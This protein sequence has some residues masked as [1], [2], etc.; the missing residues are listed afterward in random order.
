MELVQSILKEN[1]YYQAGRK[2]VVKG[3]MLHSV[4]CPQPNAEV[5]IKAWNNKYY[6]STCVHG[7]ID[8]NTGKVY[9]TLPWNHRGVHAGGAANN[10]HIGI[11]MCEPGQIRYLSDYVTVEYSEADKPAI[12]AV[13]ART[14]SSAVELFAML[15][16]KY[17]LDPL[18]NGVIVSHKEGCALGIASNHA[19]PTHLWDQLNTGFTMDGFR[20][21]VAAA[22]SRSAVEEKPESFLVRVSV[23]NLNIRKGPG[24]NFSVT[25]NY[26]GKGVFTI[27]DVSDG[28]GSS[29]GWGL[30]KSYSSKR[31]GWVS[32]DY[33]TRL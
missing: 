7:V 26:T 13:I 11:E 27:V 12:L 2:I 33:C 14:Y 29:S 6:V 23:P 20:K 9:Q 30:L 8:G 17:N 32:L 22:M 19:D 5:F 4:A 28:N 16:E 25:G 3:L 24:T 10:T 31:N 21:D 18:E 15:A 1:I